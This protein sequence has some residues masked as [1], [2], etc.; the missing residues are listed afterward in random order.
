[1]IYDAHGVNVVTGK[2]VIIEDDELMSSILV[3]MLTDMGGSCVS[4]IT[5]DDALMN[6]LQDNTP[7]S[8]VVTDH[9]LPGQL[10]G[11]EFALMVKERW[12]TVPVVVTSGFGFNIVGEL[13]A[14]A[15]FLPKPWSVQQMVEAVIFLVK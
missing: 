14:G 12:P 4:F 3:E 2:V 9:T 10:S 13:P 5:A 15:V 6:M 11:H 7:C 8:L 1:M